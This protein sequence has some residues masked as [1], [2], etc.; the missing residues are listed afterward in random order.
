MRAAAF[1]F[2]PFAIRS[3]V[4]PKVSRGVVCRFYQRRADVAKISP[5][6]AE[7]LQAKLTE[8]PAFVVATVRSRA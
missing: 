4:L 1:I 5:V 7:V 8:S 6:E 3:T 2:L